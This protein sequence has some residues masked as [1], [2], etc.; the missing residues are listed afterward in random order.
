MKNLL[1]ASN[2]HN[3]PLSL[4]QEG[5][6]QDLSEQDLKKV[7]GG[8]G[9]ENNFCGDSRHNDC[10]YNFG[11]R[12][13]G[14]C[15]FLFGGDDDDDDGGYGYRRFRYFRHYRDFYCGC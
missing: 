15:G 2:T 5:A 10:G 7:N 8:C 1:S 3:M 11:L 9:R 6:M 14:G 4:E 13:D 12:F